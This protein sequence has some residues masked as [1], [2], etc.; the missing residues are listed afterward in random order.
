M[1]AVAASTTKNSTQ[2]EGSGTVLGTSVIVRVV[3]VSPDL[4]L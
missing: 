3:A 2:L 4:E 1:Y